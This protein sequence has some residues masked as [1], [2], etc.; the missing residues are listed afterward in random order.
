M[1]KIKQQ[2]YNKESISSIKPETCCSLLQILKNIYCENFFKKNIVRLLDPFYRFLN[3]IKQEYYN[4]NQNH[5]ICKL[6]IDF[7]IFF[8]FPSN[9]RI[10]PKNVWKEHNFQ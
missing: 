7:L 1:Q 4:K 5:K 10:G 9:I 6:Q 3:L 8:L 2:F